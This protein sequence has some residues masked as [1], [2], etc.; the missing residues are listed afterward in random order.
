MAEKLTGL[1]DSMQKEFSE[2]EASL[3][4]AERGLGILE[5]MGDLDTRTK[6]EFNKAKERL[7]QLKGALAEALK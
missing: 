4:E 6:A 1:L 5:K 2:A 7:N 3:R